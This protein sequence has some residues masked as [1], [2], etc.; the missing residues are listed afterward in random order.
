[1]PARRGKG[2][3]VT[4]ARPAPP[5]APLP[6]HAQRGRP[7][8]SS[9]TR[10]QKEIEPDAVGYGLVH[11]AEG[12]RFDGLR[13]VAEGV[14]NPTDGCS[15]G[16]ARSSCWVVFCRSAPWPRCPEIGHSAQGRVSQKAVWALWSAKNDKQMLIV[17]SRQRRVPTSCRPHLSRLSMSAAQRCGNPLPT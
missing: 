15:R 2:R 11:G 13:L 12:P 14:V 4:T 6:H 8:G 17:G 10:S 7:E 5:T 9:K 16:L 1:M 3:A